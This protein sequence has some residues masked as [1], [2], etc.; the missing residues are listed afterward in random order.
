MKPP[1]NHMML[2]DDTLADEFDAILGYRTSHESLVLGEDSDMAVLGLPTF[3]HSF[4]TFRAMWDDFFTVAMGDTQGSGTT[5]GSAGAGGAWFYSRAST[6]ETAGAGNYT[7]GRMHLSCTASG[8]RITVKPN[9]RATT[10]GAAACV[11]MQEGGQPFL[12]AASLS[13]NWTTSGAIGGVF[14]VSNTQ[15]A[16]WTVSGIDTIDAGIGFYF[17]GANL[18]CSFS[19]FDIAANLEVEEVLLA[20]PGGG[21]HKCEALVTPLGIG[22]G[23]EVKWYLDGALVRTDTGVGANSANMVLAPMFELSST[24]SGTRTMGVDYIYAAQ[25]L[26]SAR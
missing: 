20:N 26:T 22:N 21:F 15:T 5:G 16:G 11:D 10:G 6:T 12:V 17:D 2:N 14:F 9:T 18:K 25:Q 24:T 7:N 3:Q 23:Y 19:W 1:L 4:T 8:N 13:P